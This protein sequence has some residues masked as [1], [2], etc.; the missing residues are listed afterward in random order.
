MVV[1]GPFCMAHSLVVVGQMLRA[2]HAGGRSR[3]GGMHSFNSEPTHCQKA[4]AAVQHMG[5]SARPMRPHRPQSRPTTNSCKRSGDK[6]P[7]GNAKI[8][9]ANW[10]GRRGRYL[11]T[12]RDI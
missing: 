7:R 2:A 5:R 3:I 6:G 12:T 11:T 1:L 8:S 10:F 9:G 4:W